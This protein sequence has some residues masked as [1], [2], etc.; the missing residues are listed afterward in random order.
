MSKKLTARQRRKAGCGLLA[1]SVLG[2]SLAA[3]AA[4]TSGSATA[5]PVTPASATTPIQ[6]VVVL[7]DENISFDHYFGT[8]P[9]AAN[10]DGPAFTAKAGTAGLRGSSQT[11]TNLIADALARGKTVLF[12][13]EKMAALEV[14]ARRLGAVG[15]RDACLEL[16]SQKTKKADFY[17]ELRRVQELAYPGLAKGQAELEMLEARRAELNAYCEAINLP[18]EGRLHQ[19]AL[20]PPEVALAGEEASPSVSFACLSR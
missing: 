20:R 11:I 19:L 15:L 1:A 13:A 9:Y 2:G 6:H 4:T 5:A 18:V 10:T 16:H 3:Y 8:Y 12:V 14:V 7:F 17:R